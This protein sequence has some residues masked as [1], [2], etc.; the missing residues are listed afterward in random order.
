MKL[1]L[2]ILTPEPV[3]KQIEQFLRNQILNGKLLPG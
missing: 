3:H 2:Q 1:N